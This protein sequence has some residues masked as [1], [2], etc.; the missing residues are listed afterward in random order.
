MC[1]YNLTQ[2]NRKW[3]YSNSAAD[4]PTTTMAAGYQKLI[5]PKVSEVIGCS[6]YK[7][8]SRF[9]FVADTI[10]TSRFSWLPELIILLCD[11]KLAWRLPTTLTSSRVSS[12]E[13]SDLDT[14]PGSLLFVLN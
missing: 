3:K 10:E 4:L 13:C 11:I 2:Q 8:D 5:F 9:S 1:I 14:G 6:N 7:F 12:I